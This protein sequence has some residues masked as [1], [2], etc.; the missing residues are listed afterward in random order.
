MKGTYWFAGFVE[1]VIK[2]EGTFDGLFE[3]D[4]S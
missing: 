3:E 2:G 1:V 4:L